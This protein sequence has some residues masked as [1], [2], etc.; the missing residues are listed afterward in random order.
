MELSVYCEDG[1]NGSLHGGGFRVFVVWFLDI[2]HEGLVDTLLFLQ[3]VKVGSV[4]V[5]TPL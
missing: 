3:A 4:G 1:A 5:E 2:D